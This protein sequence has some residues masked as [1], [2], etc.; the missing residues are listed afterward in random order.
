MKNNLYILFLLALTSC[1]QQNPIEKLLIS[2]PNESWCY[3]STN[4]SHNIYF[5]FNDNKTS[6]RYERDT[7]G[8]FIKYP[9]NSYTDAGP[10]KWSVSKDSIMNWGN[11]TYDVVSC[12]DKAIVLLYLTKEKPYLNYIFL[13]KEN[14]SDSKKFPNDFDEKR[15]Y[16]PEKYRLR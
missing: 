12:N 4:N 3:Y 8:D 1:G 13:I 9:T 10:D 7:N 6:I 11:F 15:I 14:E 16:N 2:K 5:K